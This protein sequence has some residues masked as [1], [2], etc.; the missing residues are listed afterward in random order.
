MFG[1]FLRGEK[2]GER[3]RGR[4]E[5][6]LAALQAGTG[7]KHERGGDLEQ[8]GRGG[9]SGDRLG[10]EAEL[11]R[12]ARTAGGTPRA[13][14]KLRGRLTHGLLGRIEPPLTLPRC[15][16]FSVGSRNNGSDPGC[17]WQG[18]GIITLPCVSLVSPSRVLPPLAPNRARSE[19]LGTLRAST[20]AA[21]ATVLYISCWV[22][23]SE[24][25]PEPHPPSLAPHT[26]S[27]HRAPAPLRARSSAP[28][29]VPAPSPR[30][31]SALPPPLGAA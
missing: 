16:W 11:Q 2:E 14:W 4:R 17:C 25:N 29:S 31:G 24:P 7:C 13:A 22:H 30:R 5:R 9:E 20:A 6:W 27:E 23:L 10:G 26:S 12:T 21:R 1:V 28:S 19:A 3:E 8:S 18:G 15:S